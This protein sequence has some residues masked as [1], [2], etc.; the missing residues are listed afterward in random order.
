MLKNCDINIRRRAF[1]KFIAASPLFAHV[2][3]LNALEDPAVLDSDLKYL[4]SLTRELALSSSKAM[5]V[6]DLEAVARN[7]LPPAHYGYIATGVTDERSQVANR[8]AYKNIQLKV[9]R[10]IDVSN[11]DTSVN[12]FGVKWPSPIA[13]APT[14][15]QKAFHVEGE[16]A[17]ANA[18]RTRKQ[19][20]MLSTATTTS[21]EDVNKARGEPVWYQLYTGSYWPSVLSLIKRVEAAGCPA[22]VLTVDGTGASARETLESFKQLDDRECESCHGKTAASNLDRHPMAKGLLRKGN[23]AFDWSLVDKIRSAT[24]M[25]FLIKGIGSAEDASICLKH[26][27]DGIIVSNHGG[28]VDVSGLG[29]VEVLPEVVH[30][31]AGRIPILIDGGIRRGSDVFK[32]L[33]I[34]ATAVCIGRPYLWGLG[35][36][37]QAGVERTLDILNDELIRTMKQMGTTSIKHITSKSLLFR[38]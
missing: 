29:T 21:I 36:F 8:E 32:A 34:G 10:L 27:V 38:S 15:S 19:L 30:A 37:G 1:L 3:M 12:I 7:K 11:V 24:D 16:I 25:K 26:G 4:L 20:M 22:L 14:G 6:F 28:R 31:I 33:A 2:N 9:R 17:V 35:A 23:L 5:N 13:I 18:A